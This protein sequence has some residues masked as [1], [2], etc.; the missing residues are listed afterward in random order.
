MDRLL[1]A[2]AACM[3]TIFGC[4]AAFAGAAPAEP[5]P[6]RDEVR[7]AI[8]VYDRAPL[9]EPGAAAG[10]IV[11]DYAERGPGVLVI[12]GE[13]LPWLGGNVDADVS[14]LLTGAWIVGA[15]HWQIDGGELGQACTAFEQVFHVYGLLQDADPNVRVKEVYRLSRL[16]ARGRLPATCAEIDAQASREGAHG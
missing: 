5:V 3:I 14:A 7:A 15:V 8:A 16:K 12:S 13:A 4:P 9:S 11:L 10:R 2:A 6:S 1:A